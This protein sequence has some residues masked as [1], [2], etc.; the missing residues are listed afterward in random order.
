M[1]RFPRAPFRLVGDLYYQDAD[2]D[3][4]VDEQHFR[5]GIVTTD[6]RDAI[7]HYIAQ[8]SNGEDVLPSYNDLFREDKMMGLL[9]DRDTT[10]W[11]GGKR[12]LDIRV[13]LEK[14]HPD[15]CD[16]NMRGAIDS[17]D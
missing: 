14:A 17:N 11:L 2:D 3:I 1:K 13:L 5:L 6:Q 7:Q 12:V 15:H 10:F 16:T 8:L 4:I 9:M